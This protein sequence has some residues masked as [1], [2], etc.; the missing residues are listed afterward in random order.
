M[1]GGKCGAPPPLSIKANEQG[2]KGS[3][4]GLENVSL[5]GKGSMCC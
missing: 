4:T 1:A 2:S 3:C 5:V